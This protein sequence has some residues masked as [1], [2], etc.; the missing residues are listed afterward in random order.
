WF[1]ATGT[2]D[3]YSNPT[4]FTGSGNVH[5]IRGGFG[6]TIESAFTPANAMQGN[7]FFSFYTTAKHSSTMLTGNMVMNAMLVNADITALFGRGANFPSRPSQVDLNGGNYSLL[8]SHTFPFYGSNANLNSGSF[9][10]AAL[11]VELAESY[12]SLWFYPDEGAQRLDVFLDEV[13]LIPDD[14]SAGEDF[15]STGCDF[16]GGPFCMLSDVPVR[17]QWFEVTGV[18]ETLIAEYTVLNG[19]AT[20]VNGDV[21]HQTQQLFIEP[22]QTTTYRVRR[23]LTTPHNLPSS[24]E[25]CTLEDDVTVT[26]LPS[27][28]MPEFGVLSESCGEVTFFLNNLHPGDSYLINYGDGSSGTAIVHAYEN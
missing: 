22:E 23:S 19:V 2:I 18:N 5:M 20:V 15:V 16:L 3:Y 27:P 21:D 11:C 14:F 7:Y 13:E 26:V 10:R 24:F 28:P 12:S 6:S 8:T 9:S 1:G 17:Y 4:A 25:F